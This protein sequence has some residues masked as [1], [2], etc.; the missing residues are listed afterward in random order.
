MAEEIYKTKC[1]IKRRIERVKIKKVRN[2]NLLA[3][4]LAKNITLPELAREIDV[5]LKSVERWI[6]RWRKPSAENI[7]KICNFLDKTECVLFGKKAYNKAHI[8]E[9]RIKIGYNQ[10]VAQNRE[11]LAG[12]LLI[13]GL[14]FK[15]VC[16]NTSF[17][18]EEL[19]EII[20]KGK[21]ISKEKMKELAE[22]INY[23]AFLLF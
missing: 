8:K 12:I 19:K 10:P 5:S 3:V 21:E 15:E 22:F 13:E 9:G 14:S 6:Y 7:D 1:N 4:L 11:L 18:G 17:T 20:F 23:P 16:F 2:R